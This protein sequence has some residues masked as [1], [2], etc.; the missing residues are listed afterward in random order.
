M[1]DAH[2]WDGGLDKLLRDFETLL[3]SGD[4]LYSAEDYDEALDAYERSLRAAGDDT[5]RAEAYC[6]VGDALLALARGGEALA[7]YGKAVDL[8][9]DFAGGYCGQADVHFE[10]WD[11]DR[12]RE[13][14]R[15][16]LVRDPDYARAHYLYALILEK[17]G[18]NGAARDRFRKAAA[19][20]AEYYPLPLEIE[21]EAFAPLV[22]QA[23]RG[24]PPAIREALAD[25]AI[26]LRLL[27]DVAEAPSLSELQISPQV[28]AL[29]YEAA[30]EGDDD[31][32]GREHGPMRLVLFQRNIEKLGTTHDALVEEIKKGI[33]YEVSDLSEEPS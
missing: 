23:V 11:F 8:D 33:L 5:Q 12:S 13:M 17:R 26:E 28:P 22:S 24:L 4:R 32:K 15:S 3:D 10:R 9:P 2:E 20:D 14:L 16:A 7:M 18:E 27:P 21:A 25:V 19:L 29:L 6:A 31:G 30:E 1:L